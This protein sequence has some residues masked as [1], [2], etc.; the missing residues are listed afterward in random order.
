MN[1]AIW[2][3]AARHNSQFYQ[4]Y[5]G[6]IEHVIAPTTLTS[7]PGVGP[8]HQQVTAPIQVTKTVAVLRALQE[9][10]PE[11]KLPARLV[12]CSDEEVEAW[13]KEHPELAPV[14]TE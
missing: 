13:L 8:V 12:Q 11:T 14:E 4:E 3:K 6:V 10:D 2:V 1:E 9:V 7:V 5:D